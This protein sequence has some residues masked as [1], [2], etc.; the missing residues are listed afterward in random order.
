MLQ[1]QPRE[2]GLE[3]INLQLD[4][5]T[6]MANNLGGFANNSDVPQHI[7]ISRAAVRDDGSPVDLRIANASSY[8]AFNVLNNGLKVRENGTFGAINL[9]AAREN[10]ERATYVEL[11]F[12]F[13]SGL[14]GEPLS[15]GSP[16]ECMGE[17]GH[18]SFAFDGQLKTLALANVGEGI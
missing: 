8:E 14:S 9:R 17:V 11:N 18:D 6:V 2:P 3:Y 7:H 12:S 1:C 4:R 13:L 5:A 10:G 15:V 16:A